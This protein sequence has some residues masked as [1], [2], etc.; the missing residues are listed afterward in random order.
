MSAFA[1][2]SIAALALRDPRVAELLRAHGVRYCCDGAATLHELAD[3]DQRARALLTSVEEVLGA[4]D[5]ALQPLHALST[6]ELLEHILDQ[7]HAHVWARAPFL[8]Q[9]AAELAALQL[10]TTKDLFTVAQLLNE[11]EGALM[12]HLRRE[13]GLY[14]GLLAGVISERALA[15]SLAL[16]TRDHDRIGTLVERLRRRTHG[17]TAPAGAS[18]AHRDLFREL[19]ELDA[20]V[21]SQVLLEDHVLLRRLERAAG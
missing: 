16:V 2:H 19:D 9:I 4:P 7:E 14:R 11:L 1:D 15:R 8:G 17:Y 12:G 3:A 18:N 5:P 13:E 20:R 10:D 6:E 21:R